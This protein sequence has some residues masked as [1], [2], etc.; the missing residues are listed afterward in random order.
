MPICRDDSLSLEDYQIGVMRLL[1]GIHP[2]LAQAIL[3]AMVLF[4]SGFSHASDP[5]ATLDE[6]LDLFDSHRFENAEDLLVNLVKDS[7]FR[8]LDY[9]QQALAYSHIAYSQIN[10]GHEKD[11]LTFI[12]KA[13]DVSKRE[14]GEK[15]LMYIRHLKTKA[16]ALYWAD[17]RREA[18]RVAEKM[19]YLLER[20]GD[21]YRE[22]QQQVRR[23]ISTILKSN[24]LEEEL[25]YDMSEF[26]TA[27][28]NI[29]ENI[30]LSMAASIMHDYKLVGKDFKPSYKKASYFK[31]THLMKV[32]E[33]STD[34]RN[35]L[36]YIPSEDHMND[37]CVVYRNGDKVKNAVVSYGS[38]K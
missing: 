11:S 5:V 34:R 29:D 24:L 16:V 35:R 8:R 28:E 17:K 33:S 30:S 10:Q 1:S 32:R 21:D 4:G 27:C 13:L 19:E 14:F 18:R 36:I 37:W 12:D 23:M 3:A 9:T 15:S 22:E 7:S 2:F 31:N 26:Y 25:P 20:M 6:G 38:D